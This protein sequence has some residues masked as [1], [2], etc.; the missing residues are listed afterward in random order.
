MS[1]IDPLS[2]AIKFSRVANLEGSH[3]KGIAGIGIHALSNSPMTLREIMLEHHEYSLTFE[4]YVVPSY[5]EL[6]RDIGLMIC[7][8]MVEVEL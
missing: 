4:D 1:T 6:I 7:F 2:S 8:G 5:G 3:P